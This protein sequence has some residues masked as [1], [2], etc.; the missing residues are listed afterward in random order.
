MQ[1]GPEPGSA[2]ILKY[3]TPAERRVTSS[4]RNQ[5]SWAE[6][7]LLANL[8]TD[9]GFCASRRTGELLYRVNSGRKAVGV[10]ELSWRIS[11]KGADLQK[12]SEALAYSW[13]ESI[14]CGLHLI[15]QRRFTADLMYKK[16]RSAEMSVLQNG[17]VLTWFM[18]DC[19]CLDAWLRNV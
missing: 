2:E 16:S 15:P 4:K 5:T 12:Q 6:W 11:G 17:S 19:H 8:E 18:F 13:Y 9:Q 7:S 1:Y 14:V 10:V 3:K